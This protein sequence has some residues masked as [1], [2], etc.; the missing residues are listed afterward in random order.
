[1]KQKTYYHIILDQI[2]SKQDR[3]YSMIIFF[4]INYKW[5]DTTINYQLI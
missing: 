4:L 3:L 5:Y 1:M 2:N